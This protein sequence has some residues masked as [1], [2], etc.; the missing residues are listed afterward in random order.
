MS[1][2][3][4]SREIMDSFLADLRAKGIKPSKAC[5]KFCELMSEET[6]DGLREVSD[7]LMMLMLL[8]GSPEDRREVLSTMDTCPCCDRWLGHNKP[9]ADDDGPPRRQT[10]FDFKR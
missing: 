4:S 9:P 2:E 10:S 6:R 5:M 3:R 1:T 8:D 7:H